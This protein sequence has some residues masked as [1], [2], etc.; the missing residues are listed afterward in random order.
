MS[1]YKD[2]NKY[3]SRVNFSILVDYLLMNGSLR[4]YKKG[5]YFS[6]LDSK[7][8]YMGYVVS[9]AFRYNCADCEGKLGL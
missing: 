4:H 8:N 3:T 1:N 6:R 9:G 5:D 7:C 2:Y